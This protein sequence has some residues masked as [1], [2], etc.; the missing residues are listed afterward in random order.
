MA[1]STNT[2][3]D[4]NALMTALDTFAVANGWTSDEINTAGGES[5]M[6]RN[7]VWVSFKRATS[8]PT[9]LSVYQALGYGGT[10]GAG[11]DDSGNGYNGP[12]AW[13]DS[14]AAL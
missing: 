13:S 8:S 10:P 11:T 4:L 6:H 5:A 12:S 3:A 9:N 14:N 2:A 1:F 7:S